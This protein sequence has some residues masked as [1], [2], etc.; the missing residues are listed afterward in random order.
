M[1]PSVELLMGHVTCEG[2]AEMDAVPP[3]E[4]SHWGPRWSS[5]W[6]HETCEGCAE[7]GAVPPCERSHW[8]PRWSSLW[9]HEPRERCAEMG[10]RWAGRTHA[11]CATGAFGGAPHGATNRVRGVPEWVSMRGRGACGH[12][13][14]GLRWSS[15]WGHEPCEGCATMGAVTQANA[16]SGAFGGAPYGATNHVRGVPKRV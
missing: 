10:L 7:M 3:C 11:N 6:G 15:L 4:R 2:Y 12:G 16:A 8:G 14:W 9:G 5:L 1:G 13:H